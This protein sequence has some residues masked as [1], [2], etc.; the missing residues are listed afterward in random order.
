M[1]DIQQVVDELR[2][3]VQREVVENSDE[4]KELLESYSAA[5]VE[6]NERLRKC[7]SLLKR[8]LRSEAL[9]IAEAKPSLLDQ[10]AVLDFPERDE[11]VDIINL[12]FLPPPQPL[13]FEVAT[14]LNAAYADQEPIKK[15]LDQHRIMALARAPLTARLSVLKS[16]AEIDAT[17]PHW[18]DDVREME[19]ARFRQIDAESLVAFKEGNSSVLKSL[20]MEVQ[21]TTWMETVPV[22]L[23]RDLKARSGQATRG[24]AKARL[25]ELSE[26]LHTAFSALD[27]QAA[28]PLRDEWNQNRKLASLSETDPLA[29]GVAPILAW[30]E[31]EDRREADARAFVRLTSDIERA[32]EDDDVSL[33]ELS[34]LSF[35]V[36]RSEKSLPTLLES[37][38][39]NRLGTLNLAERRKKKLMFGVWG[40]SAAIVIAI[41]GFVAY[42]SVANEKTRRLAEAASTLIQDGN[43]EEARKLIEREGSRSTAESWLAV[44]KG[45]AEAKQAERDRV[46]NW[47]ALVATARESDDATAVGDAIKQAREL[48]K[49]AEEKIEVGQLQSVWQ[50]RMAEIATERDR[51]FREAVASATAAMKN[52]DA[53]LD[54]S[55][56]HDPDAV[57]SLAEALDVQMARLLPLRQTVGKELATQATLLESRWKASRQAIAD[58]GTKRGLFEKLNDAV[59]LLPGNTDLSAKSG[60]YAAILQE[61][62][63]A[64]PNDARLVSVKT[65]LAVN[66]L[67]L[68]VAR[69]KILE[70]WKQRKPKDQKELE[71]RLKDVREFLSENLASPDHEMMSEYEA[72]LAS[73]MRRYE[74]DGDPDEG[75]IRRM[76]SLY[77]S[78]FIKEAFTLRTDENKTYYVPQPKK[79]KD[80]I[81]EFG[82][83]YLI[84]FNGETKRAKFS[85]GQILTKGTETPAQVGIAAKVR[86]RIISVGLDEWSDYFQELMTT[87]INADKVDPFLRYLL[88]L[89][90]VEYAGRGDAILEEELAPLRDRLSNAQIDQSVAWM[91]PTNANAESA[92]QSAKEVLEQLPAVE[93]LFGR[94]SA[95]RKQFESLVFAHRFAVGWLEQDPRGGWVLQTKWKPDGEFDLFV[96]T[97]PD[98]DGKRTWVPLGHVKVQSTKIDES[99]ARSVGDLS[100]VF[101]LPSGIDS[102]L[103]TNP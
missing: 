71:A 98:E 96:A 46:T 67:P 38:L 25:E 18:E 75:M 8:G 68:V 19:R 5:C 59:L 102:R 65:A 80:L 3:L 72:Y 70:R 79:E 55:Q 45:F 13:L 35:S 64:F 42:I 4:L 37:R 2:F 100:V 23:S 10:V 54:P 47:T 12:Y 22:S 30:V 43:L 91:D 44:K 90:T 27:A 86:A 16:I 36:E 57:R 51:V 49:T 41:L 53:G 84:G 62:L 50:K 58:M 29:E 61:Y 7:D 101:A 17:T 60:R 9:Q 15:L 69:E 40:G 48:S 26:E 11:L 63:K 95:R 88:I 31:D 39:R 97:H 34:K 87:L 28:R 74:D 21:S 93:E 66:P 94:A 56:P 33:E 24:H 89:K 76:Q 20:M 73:A 77:N 92:R 81:G 6:V 103:S 82:V 14:A 1:N 32:L 83:D 78:K 52:L 99:V 85:A